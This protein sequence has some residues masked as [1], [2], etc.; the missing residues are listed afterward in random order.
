MPSLQQALRVF[1]QLGIL[2]DLLK[3][4]Q[5]VSGLCYLRQDGTLIGRNDMSG[6]A[7]R[8]GFPTMM[9]PR[10]EL[11]NV[12]LS[13]I[14]KGR[15]VM[16]KR[17]LE[18]AQDT[19][20]VIAKCADGSL[21]YADIMIGSD[22]AY[23]A[24]RQRLY[25]TEAAKGVDIPASDRGRLRF[26][27]FALVGV[28]NLTGT[29]SLKD[30]SGEASDLFVTVSDKLPYSTWV[31]PL[32]DNRIGWGIAGNLLTT[33][34]HDE[35]NFK[36]SNWGA[37]YVDEAIE[38]VLELPCPLGGKFSTLVKAT[39]RELIS[40]VMLEDKCFSTWHGGRIVLLGDACHKLIPFAGQGAIQAILDAVCLSN[41]LSELPSNRQ[42]DI[43]RAFEAYARIRRPIASAA[44]DTSIL[45][46]KV[47][48]G[49]TFLNN[50][51][52]RLVF[53]MPKFLYNRVLDKMYAGRPIAYFL[54]AACLQGTTPD[55]TP[56]MTAYPNG[57]PV[58]HRRR[59]QRNMATRDASPAADGGKTAEGN[60]RSRSCTGS[61]NASNAPT[62]L[63]AASGPPSTATSA[64]ASNAH[65]SSSGKGNDVVKATGNQR[66][67]RQKQRL[68]HGSK[69]TFVA[70]SPSDVS[71]GGDGD[72]DGNGDDSQDLSPHYF[73]AGR[74]FNQGSFHRG[75]KPR[76]RRPS[77]SG[78]Q[79]Q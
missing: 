34:V 44:V 55:S 7:E 17:I 47:V 21:F 54:P 39:D 19:Q 6:M 5:P 26:N 8:F 43:E 14:K 64:A 67:Q 3:I 16:N 4:G 11:M 74:S 52:R 77:Q 18:V 27:Q 12:L 59:I 38:Q 2:P 62:G 63:D 1:E 15:I 20:Y 57:L 33:Q 76:P 31:M 32:K 68:V 41:L 30:L 70:T 9:F 50:W 45:M 66:S 60:S 78:M 61:T 72:G 53:N 48:S 46:M 56:N 13:R 37:E 69:V 42:Q 51:C 25:L 22:G 75:A 10:P 71:D 79:T 58:R 29:E 36:H 65:G 40:K 23:S 28:A 49:K 35:A 24:V 73:V